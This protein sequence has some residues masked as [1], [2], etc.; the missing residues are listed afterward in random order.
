MKNRGKPAYRLIVIKTSK[1]GDFFRDHPYVSQMCQGKNG[2]SPAYTKHTFLKRAQSTRR[3]G[4]VIALRH[5]ASKTVVGFALCTLH[6]NKKHVP[7]KRV[8]F[9]HLLC[10]DENYRGAGGVVLRGTERFAAAQGAR[11][12]ILQSIVAALGFY[13]RNGYRRGVGDR[14][15]KAV[16]AAKAEFQQLQERFVI[17]NNDDKYMDLLQGEYYPKMNHPE[18]TIVMFK[19]LR[20]VSARKGKHWDWIGKTFKSEKTRILARYHE[21]STHRRWT[22][23]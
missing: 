1:L 14:S 8:L 21:N 12:S 3:H 13:K 23:A 5:A 10:A 15:R 17:I 7:V 22:R 19:Q 9:I 16:A 20:G 6:R 18:Q 11:F 4:F 2:V